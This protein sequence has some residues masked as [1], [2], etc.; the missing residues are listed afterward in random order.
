M[1]FI[2]EDQQKFEIDILRPIVDIRKTKY[3]TDRELTKRS[4]L[5]FALGR[6][7]TKAR[8]TCLNSPALA[9][10]VSIHPEVCRI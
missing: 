8:R 1:V 9:D 5:A 4:A 7:A 3:R 6:R 10:P 2:Q